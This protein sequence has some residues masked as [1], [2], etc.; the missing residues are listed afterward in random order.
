MESTKNSAWE[1]YRNTF[2]GEAAM[3]DLA[4]EGN[5]EALKKTIP[6]VQNLEERTERGYTILMLSAYKGHLDVTRL[7]IEAGADV[8]TTDDSG[9]SVLMGVAFKGHRDVAR[10]LL[11]GGANPNY[12]NHRGQNAL[13]FAEMFGRRDL[14]DLLSSTQQIE[15]SW[16]LRRL[17]SWFNAIF[18]SR[19]QKEAV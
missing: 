1:A 19:K 2:S 3:F 8:N 14:A 17:Q 15:R 9:N 11:N 18:Y 13:Q 16:I 5:L 6:L 12:T 4:R 7:L 10:A